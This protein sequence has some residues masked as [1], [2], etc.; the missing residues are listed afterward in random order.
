MTVQA[1][2]PLLFN[3]R[4]LLSPHLPF[5]PPPIPLC[6]CSP[7]FPPP[8]ISPPF[9]HSGLVGAALSIRSV[10]PSSLSLSMLRAP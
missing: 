1:S 4:H 10:F 5:I 2:L 9:S 6:E 7:S 8:P 3:L